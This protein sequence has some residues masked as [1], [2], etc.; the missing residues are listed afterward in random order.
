VLL[1]G[2]RLL[3][4]ETRYDRDMR[5]GSEIDMAIVRDENE[6]RR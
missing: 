1:L 3:G 5:G 2:L 4:D 6:R